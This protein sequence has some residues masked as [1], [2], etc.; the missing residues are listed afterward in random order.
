MPGHLLRIG[1]PHRPETLR[2]YSTSKKTP[3]VTVAEQQQP[4]QPVQPQVKEHKEGKGKL[5][6]ERRYSTMDHIFHRDKRRSLGGGTRSS[7]GGSPKLGP[8]K[9]A[10]MD[11]I[12]ESPPP[13]FVGTSASSSGALLSGRL[14]VTVV[15][16]EVTLDKF[17]TQLLAVVTMKK[18]VSKDCPDCKTQTT[19]MFKWN[20]WNHAVTLQKGEYEYPFSYLIPGHLPATSHGSLGM[21]DYYLA[22]T[23]H[24]VT[25]DAISFRQ[26]LKIQRAV[27]PGSDKSSM[28]VFPP[29]NLTARVVLPPVIHPIG[30]FDAEMSLN[31]VN[32]MKKDTHTRWKIRKVDWRIEEHQKMISPACA[33]HAHKVGGENKG[34]LHQDT[35]IIGGEEIREGWKNDFDTAGGQIDLA[36]TA[37]I[38]PGEKPLCDVESPVGLEVKHTLVIELIVAEEFCSSSNLNSM[39]P[40]GSARVLRMQFALFV[41][42]RAGLGISWDQEQPPLYSDVPASPPLYHNAN[43]EDYGGPPLDYESLE[44]MDRRSR[45]R[46]RGESRLRTLI[47]SDDLDAEPDRTQ[48]DSGEQDAAQPEPSPDRR[49]RIL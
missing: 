23:A 9:P 18:P 40:T 33:K 27:P 15:H 47:T 49:G 16:P 3:A 43:V 24:A 44:E 34:I 17:D 31:G 20:M 48:E 19:E 32:E 29:T 6:S 22:A 36:F 42:E 25:G 14:K 12:I 10:I 38:K 8:V 21:V 26:P 45:S 37:G 35:R 30:T 13:V 41:T 46:A 39:T 28:R 4:Q 5:A 7:S 1:K 2:D 11:V